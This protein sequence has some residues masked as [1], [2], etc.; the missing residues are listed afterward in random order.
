MTLL[1]VKS[2]KVFR[3]LTDLERFASKDEEEVYELLDHLNS[4]D[5]KK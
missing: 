5:V 1:L 3:P 2:D 4:Q